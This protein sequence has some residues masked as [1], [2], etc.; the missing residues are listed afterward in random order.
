MKKIYLALSIA[1]LALVGS[2]CQKNLDIPQKSVLDTDIIYENVS[3][4]DAEALIGSV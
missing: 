4:E 3:V 1:A 2:S